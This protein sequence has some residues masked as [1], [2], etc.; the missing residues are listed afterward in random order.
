MPKK[1]FRYFFPIFKTNPELVY[2][3][4]ASTSL[5]PQKVINELNSFYNNNGIG[6]KSL[7]PLGSQNDLLLNET[8]K[9]TANFINALPEEIIFTKGTTDSLNLLAQSLS[10]ILEEGDE[11]ITS[12]LEHNS[13]VLPWLQQEKIKKAKIVFVPLNE[14][15]KITVENFAKV[16]T[17]KTKVV[18]LTHISNVLGYQT[19]IK[20]ITV[21]AHQKNAL[22]ILDAAQ[23]VG[24]LP[25][26]VKTLDIDFLAFSSHKLYGP[27]GVGILFGKNHLLKKLKPTFF[28][29]SSIKEF[30]TTHIC[31]N[32]SPYKF[33]PG[34]FNI[35]DIIG[36]KKALE[37]I[38]E[39]GF[40]NIEKQ[41]QKIYQKI[42]KELK[43][44]DQITIYNPQAFN[45]IAFNFNNIHAHDVEIFLA[46]KNIYVR[47]GKCCAF[48]IT[49]KLKQT[50]IIRISIGIHNNEKDV[51]L[52]IENLKKVKEF[53]TS[54]EQK[55]KVLR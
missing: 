55:Q 25:I 18:A 35:A 16:L 20:E 22:V 29:G 15:N 50:S 27:F 3:D 7:A 6:N 17:A 31:F 53:F 38:E 39:I 52:L 30:S 12:Q 48:L 28:G 43:K 54:F 46:Q 13:S 5:K 4:T 42:M 1:S 47:T 49:E 21:L 32:D 9:K 23:S 36:F 10:D 34:T 40:N 44:F 51:V 45:I 24:H 37:F 8:R 11:I 19:P 2:F 33:E 26:D 14:N 41:E